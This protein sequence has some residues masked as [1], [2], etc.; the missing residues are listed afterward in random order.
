MVNLGEQFLSKS[1]YE[2]KTSLS[3]LNKTASTTKVVETD[4]KNE[5]TDDIKYME[6]FLH[7]LDNY[8]SSPK[9]TKEAS[10]ILNYLSDRKEFWSQQNK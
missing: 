4:V 10:N 5:F 7:T 3:L 2:F 9:L 1:L 8:K 6:D